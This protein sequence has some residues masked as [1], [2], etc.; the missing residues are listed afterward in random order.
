MLKQITQHQNNFKWKSYE[1]RSFISFWGLQ[2]LFWLFVHSRS[3]NLKHYTLLTL[4]H[5]DSFGINSIKFYNTY[6]DMQITS[7]KKM[8]FKVVDLE[9]Y[10]MFGIKLIILR[11]IRKLGSLLCSRWQGSKIVIKMSMSYFET[12]MHA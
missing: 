6:L 9:K 12:Q 10:C 7:N 5:M 11:H 8:N 2:L 3:F 4:H 1:L